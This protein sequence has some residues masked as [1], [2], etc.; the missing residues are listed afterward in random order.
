MDIFTA[1]EDVIELVA[2][3]PGI[4][5]EDDFLATIDDV[6]EQ[7]CAVRDAIEELRGAP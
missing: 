2:A 6:S 7:L 5:D 1:L 4:K 3:L